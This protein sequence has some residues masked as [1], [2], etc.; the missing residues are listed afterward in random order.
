MDAQGKRH[1]MWIPRLGT[2]IACTA[3]TLYL[4]PIHTL[5]SCFD[6]CRAREVNAQT[7]NE[8]SGDNPSVLTKLTTRTQCMRVT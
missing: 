2:C 6:L 5:H 1:D 4:L 7:P 3:H 8:R